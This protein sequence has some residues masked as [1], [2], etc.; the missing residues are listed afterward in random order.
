[1]KLL[2]VVKLLKYENHRFVLGYFYYKYADE[3]RTK[4]VINNK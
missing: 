4:I 3:V 2:H 1:M